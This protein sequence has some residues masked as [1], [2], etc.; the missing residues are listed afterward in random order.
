M[1][2]TGIISKHQRHWMAPKPACLSNALFT[3]IDFAST[4]AS[5]ELLVAGYSLAILILLLEIAVHR[6]IMHSAINALSDTL[7][8]KRKQNRPKIVVRERECTHKRSVLE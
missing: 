3:S 4:V 6:R 1:R 5:V 7:A 2:E 8:F